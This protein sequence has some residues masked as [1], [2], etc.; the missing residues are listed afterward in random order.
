MFLTD[1]EANIGSVYGV[2]SATFPPNGPDD[3]RPC[4]TAIDV[5][6]D[7]KNDGVTIYS[8]GYALGDKKECT[9][10]QWPVIPYQ[11]AVAEVRKNGRVVTPAKAAVPAHPCDPANTA[12]NDTFNVDCVHSAGIGTGAKDESP[13]RYSDDTVEAIASDAMGPR[14]FFFD[15][16]SAGDLSAIFAAIAT[17]IG[18]G[19]SRLVDD[20]F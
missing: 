10:G 6:E 12:E 16:A 5:A 20:G 14:K 4:Q 15:K 17:D 9:R 13:V 11:A 1:G 7:I 19:S 2:N 18:S 3:Q 8:I